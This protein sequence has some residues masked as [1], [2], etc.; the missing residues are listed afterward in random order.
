[1][2][3]RVLLHAVRNSYITFR[4]FDA[5][6]VGARLANYEEME[7]NQYVY[8]QGEV[9]RLFLAPRGP[10]SEYNYY[11]LLNKRRCYFDTSAIAHALDEQCYIVEP[12]PPGS[13]PPANGLPNFPLYYANDDD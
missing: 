7:L 5:N 13:N 8:M 2:V 11:T 4:G 6:G 12:M 10:D 9:V 3:E 1:P